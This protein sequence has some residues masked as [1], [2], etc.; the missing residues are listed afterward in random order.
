MPWLCPA[1]RLPIR[2]SDV[3]HDPRLGTVYR[4]HVCRLELIV[5]PVTRTL[6][7][8]PAPS[9]GESRGKRTVSMATATDRSRRSQR[10]R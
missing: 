8:A 9:E 3:E 1:C 2:H 6:A 4:C 10:R 5:D 7:L